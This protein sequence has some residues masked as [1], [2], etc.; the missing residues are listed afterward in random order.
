MA[1][2]YISDL[3]NAREFARFLLHSNSGNSGAILLHPSG[4]MKKSFGDRSLNVAAALTLWNALLASLRNID[5]ITVTFKSCP[6]TY[7]FKFAFSL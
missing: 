7:L 5:S 3:I 4:K 6:K 1:P 2:A